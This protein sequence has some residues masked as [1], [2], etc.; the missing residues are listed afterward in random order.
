MSTILSIFTGD[1]IF[2]CDICNKRF[3]TRTVLDA[4][5]IT[6]GDDRPFLCDLC[7]FTSKSK[8]DLSTH[9]RIH[10]GWLGFGG[11]WDI[12]CYIQH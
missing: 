2:V 9:Q 4:H 1:K 12:M 6:H 7:G 5:K 11:G 3:Y 8:S 10:K